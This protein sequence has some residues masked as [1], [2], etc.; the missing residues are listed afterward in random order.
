LQY[1][2]VPTVAQCARCHREMRHGLKQMAAVW[3]L[4]SMVGALIESIIVVDRAAYL[5]EH[6]GAGGTVGA[7][8]LFDP[9]TSPRNI[10]L[11]GQRK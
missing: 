4:R 3:A 5:S 9:V 7:F 10:V 2:W 6:C 1:P 8:A 11:V